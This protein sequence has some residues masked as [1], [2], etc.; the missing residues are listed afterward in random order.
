MYANKRFNLRLSKSSLALTIYKLC[1]F[2]VIWN[3]K[4]ASAAYKICIEV[5]AMSRATIDVTR[6]K[7]VNLRS[8]QKIFP[9]MSL[10]A[11]WTETFPHAKRRKFCLMK[12]SCW[13]WNC[14]FFSI[15]FHFHF[16][17]RFFASGFCFSFSFFFRNEQTK[18][19]N[20]HLSFCKKPFFPLRCRDF[21]ELS[22][23]SLV[24]FVC[25]LIASVMFF[26]CAFF[27]AG[28]N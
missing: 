1:L 26:S 7:N 11:M 24:A 28:N 8:H 12:I 20:F 22:F 23:F 18:K 3:W 5:V 2:W 15:V 17:P 25:K 6:H 21:S 9:Q 10:Q 27:S 14:W 19:M 16:F 13:I 4:A